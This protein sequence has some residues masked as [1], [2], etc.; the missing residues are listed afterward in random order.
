MK[1]LLSHIWPIT[2]RIESE[3]SGVMEVVS[4]NGKKYLNSKNAN[5]SYGSLQRIMEKGILE[6]DLTKVD[7]VLLL[8]MGGGSAIFSLRNKFKYERK[9]TAV[10]W[11]KKIIEIARDEFLIS[12]FDNLT[13]ENEDAFAFVN[14]IKEQYDL[15]I[16]DLFIDIEV[17]KQFYSFE[18]IEHID[19]IMSPASSLIFNLGIGEQS[20]EKRDAVIKWF[21]SKEKYGI[22]VFEKVQGYNTLLIV[23]KNVN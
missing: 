22:Q 9:I 4:S 18:F 10:E 19:R 17:P 16:I 6:V 2:K 21:R 13:I 12:K 14:R 8:G 23:H 3:Y 7:S 5:Y 11:D 15:V 1:H 20:R